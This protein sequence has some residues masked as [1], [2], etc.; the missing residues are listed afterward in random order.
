MSGNRHRPGPGSDLRSAAAR[1][2][3]TLVETGDRFAGSL[4][5]RGP[6]FSLCHIR[7]FPP[8]RRPFSPGA[9]GRRVL[10]AS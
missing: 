5:S 10:L 6:R 9:R 8:N 4:R 3:R 1:R 7:W 2:R